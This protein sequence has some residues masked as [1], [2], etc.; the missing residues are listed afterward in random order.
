MK[1]Y[2]KLTPPVLEKLA[3]RSD[4][5]CVMD[6]ETTGVY[7]KDRVVEI[8]IVTINKQGEIVEEWETLI[9]PERHMGATEIHGITPT[10]LTQAPCFADV[11]GDIA[12]R[13]D[14]AYLVGHNVSFDIRMLANEF[15]RHNGRFEASES[16]YETLRH[17][18][19]KLSEA[20]QLEGI[21]TTKW[22]SALGD[23][24]ATAELFLRCEPHSMMNS[25]AIRPVSAET[26]TLPSNRTLTRANCGG[27]PESP[28]TPDRLE[29][30][31]SLLEDVLEDGVITEEEREEM[32]LLQLAMGWSEATVESVQ[33]QYLQQQTDKAIEDGVVDI[34]EQKKLA[35][36]IEA[37]GFGSRIVDRRI[38][39]FK[40]D[41][42][43]QLIVLQGGDRIT[44]TGEH[45]MITRPEMEIV[46]TQRGLTIGNF[47][48]RYTR[49]LLAAD[50]DTESGKAQKCRE[51]GIPILPMQA[52]SQV[53]PGLEITILIR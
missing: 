25:R 29:A 13:L 27:T 19:M 52:F 16:Y 50:I 6:V 20:C 22:H 7:N 12:E 15:L 34:Q 21:V 48:K 47:A 17:Y 32:K 33:R 53:K 2:L 8:A 31:M 18:R 30:Y 37:F 23:A 40:E 41:A 42:G 28:K 51:C 3:P 38:R 1:K 44:L 46:L 4:R 36:I 10:M 11:I 49:L 35:E 9:Q 39:P 45:P 26:P 5:F 24:V 43:E 14:G